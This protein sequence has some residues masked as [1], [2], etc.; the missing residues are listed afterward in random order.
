[1]LMFSNNRVDAAAFSVTEG[2]TDA[3]QEGIWR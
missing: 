2:F 1:M 3:I